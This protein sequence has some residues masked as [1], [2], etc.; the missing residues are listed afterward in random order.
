MN[1]LTVVV[2]LIGNVVTFV[3][4][5]A[6]LANKDTKLRLIGAAAIALSIIMA[7]IALSVIASACLL[8]APLLQSSP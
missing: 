3:L 4:C 2:M 7:G 5:G 8:V 6:L 1:T